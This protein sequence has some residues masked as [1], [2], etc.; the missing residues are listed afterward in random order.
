[1]Y[2]SKEQIWQSIKRLDTV[3]PFFGITF[4]AFKQCDLPIEKTKE[5]NSVRILNNFLLNYYH[6]IADFPGFYTPLDTWNKNKKRWNSRTYANSLHV[7]ANDRFRDVLYHPKGSR[8]W[9][10]KSDYI[11]VLS[12]RYLN[13]NTLPTF[14]LAVWLFRSYDWPEDTH[15][16]DIINTF[17][18]EFSI[19]E[20]ELL[21]FDTSA[22]QPTHPWLQNAPISYENLIDIIGLPPNALIEGTSLQT[23]HLNGVGP[24]K[25][26]ELNAAPRLNLITGDNGLG[27]T[28]LLECA[29]WVLTG[30]WAGYPARP[31]QDANSVSI[32]YQIGKAQHLQ[33]PQTAK[34][35]RT[36]LRWESPTRRDTLPGITIFAQVDGSFAVWDPAKHMMASEDRYAGQTNDAFTYF[37][38]SSI[39][40]G[41]QEPD[42][43]GRVQRVTG[44]INDWIR[45]QEAADQTR[46]N[47]FSSALYALSPHPDQEPLTP[48]APTRM[49]EL[50]DRR[51]IPTLKFPYGEVPFLLCS[52]GI[53]RI[54]SLTY[55]L[56][57]A[58][59]EH[60]STAEIIRK[61][62]AQSM[63]ILIDEMEAHLHPL[64]QRTILPAL[65]NVV[66]EIASKVQVQLIIST[67]S[68]LILASAEPLFD[69]EKDKLFHLYMSNSSVKLENTPFIKRGSID[70]WLISDIFGL[71]QPRSVEAEIAI[72]EANAL[73]LTRRP[74]KAKIQTISDCLLQVLAPDDEFWPLWTY[75]AEREGG[76]RFD[77]RT[78]AT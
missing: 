66:Q 19:N 31:R 51:D 29:W 36:A 63:I 16:K 35:N 59:Q 53:Q 58:W 57:W 5:I 37:T 7:N 72:A 42:R 76:V 70:Q 52:A 69:G 55:L 25:H 65:V 38:R 24:A 45:W 49:P 1:M 47:E 26:I 44:L 67:H 3:N 75:F 23:L 77:T 71:V 13:G 18:S 14:D 48:G 32:T 40:N 10:W 11:Q 50:S 34:Y 39:L 33:K 15:P 21:L 56:I 78:N 43:Y 4:L 6:P 41:L 28:F 12:T 8:E 60:M 68:P 2:L 30:D 22:P 74:S 9:G 20:E 54:V 73:Q 62:P 17:F 64:W 46:F 61:K 27:K